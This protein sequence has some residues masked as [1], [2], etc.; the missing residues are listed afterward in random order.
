MRWSIALQ[1]NGGFHMELFILAGFLLLLLY[2]L[3]KG[4]ER[5]SKPPPPVASPP[6]VRARTLAP[7]ARTQNVAGKLS[8]LPALPHSSIYLAS[9]R[10][11]DLLVADPSGLPTLYFQMHDGRLWLTEPTTGLLVSGCNKHLRRMG[12]WSVNV[13]GLEYHKAAVRAGDFRPGSK[14]QLV[15]EPNNEFDKNAVALCAVSSDRIVGYFNKGMAPGL[16]KVL[17]SGASIDA[18]SVTGDGPGKTTGKIEV[19]AAS[20]VVLQ[21]LLRKN[22]LTTD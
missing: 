3:Y 22:P 17:D 2:F 14:V 4:V 16:A 7:R 6:P 11:N 9:D 20:R 18:I 10:W 15:R 19:V 5:A 8:V 1:G 12:I 13:R 21:H